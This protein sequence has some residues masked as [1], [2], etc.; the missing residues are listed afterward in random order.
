MDNPYN[1]VDMVRFYASTTIFIGDGCKAPFWHSTWLSGQ[2]PMD[3]ALRRKLSVKQALTKSVW[4]VQI[5][6]SDGLMAVH[7]SEIATL[8]TKL[9]MVEAQ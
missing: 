8:W 9:L 6:T 1:D 4:V 5:R 7:V 3:L 2:R